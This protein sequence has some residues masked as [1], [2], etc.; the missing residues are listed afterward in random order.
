[1]NART[2]AGQ[3]ATVGGLHLQMSP[4]LLGCLVAAVAATGALIVTLAV[5][6][7]GPPPGPPLPNGMPPPPDLGSL[8]IFPVVTGLVVLA[9]LAALVV[10]CRDQVMQRLREIQQ[11]AVADPADARRQFEGLVAELR[12][13]LADDRERE[14]RELSDRIAAMTSEYGEQRE[15]DGYLSGMRVAASNE[16]PEQKLR[17][18]RRPPR[19]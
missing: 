2:R 5:G 15:T 10:F 4:L 7:P 11:E 16:A 14:L 18:I 6:M 13:G 3:G 8:A 9:W 19:S 17:S 12:T 1:M